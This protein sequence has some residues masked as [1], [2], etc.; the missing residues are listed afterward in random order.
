MDG[1]RGEVFPARLC[2]SSLQDIPTSLLPGREHPLATAHRRDLGSAH[3]GSAPM[4][5]AVTHDWD[6]EM[7]VGSA[8]VF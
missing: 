8:A 2:I 3:R 5:P 7:G 6:R 4:A 1:A